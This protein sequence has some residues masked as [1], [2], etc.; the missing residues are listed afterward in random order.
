VRL[1]SDKDNIE[2]GQ[3]GMQFGD[4][5]ALLRNTV[6]HC[7]LGS[8]TLQRSEDVRAVAATA[9]PTSKFDAEWT[10]P[11]VLHQICA[12]RVDSDVRT[13][14]CNVY[15]PMTLTALG[16]HSLERHAC[17]HTHAN[18]SPQKPGGDGRTTQCHWPSRITQWPAECAVSASTMRR[19]LA[20]R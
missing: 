16:D 10:I 17:A 20:E 14:D 12:Q 7:W 11:S 1:S 3:L 5:F 9:H 18:R 4:S 2:L 13:S 8:G 15:D 6:T 19:W